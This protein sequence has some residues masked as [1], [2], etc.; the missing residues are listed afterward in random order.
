MPNIQDAGASSHVNLLVYGD[1]GVGKTYLIGTGGKQFKTLIVRPPIDHV[2][3]IL[4]SGVKEEVV[5]SWSDMEE[6]QQYLRHEGDE[7][8]WVWLDTISNYQDIGLSDLYEI[9][10]DKK[11]SRAEFG[12]DRPEYRVNM[13]RLEEWIRHTVGAGMFNFGVT[14]YPFWLTVPSNESPEEAVDKL[15]PWVQGKNMSQKICGYMHVVGY[16]EKS[17]ARKD[18]PARRTLYTDGNRQ[19]YAKDQFSAIGDMV[20]PTMPKIVEAINA[21]RAGSK[22]PAARRKKTT[23]RTRR[24]S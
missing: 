8:D 17:E 16:L 12:P 22:K 4:G 14:A 24:D 18:K 13:W 3:S 20:N 7:W 11:P 19:F 9:A 5:R 1:T 21:K 6:I 23:R 15:M 10:V 2:D